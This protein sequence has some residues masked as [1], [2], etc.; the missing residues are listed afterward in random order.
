MGAGSTAPA[1]LPGKA[2][3]RQPAAHA[4]DAARMRAICSDILAACRKGDAGP[5]T[6]DTLAARAGMSTFHF[7]RRFKAIVGVTPG[8]FIAAARLEHFKRRLGQNGTIGGALYDAGYGSPSRVYERAGRVLGMTPG[9]YRRGGEGLNISYAVLD[10]PVGRLLIA[11][12]DRGICCTRFGESRRALVRDLRAEYP[13]ARI[14]PARTGGNP[15]FAAWAQAIAR[16]LTGGQPHLDLPLDVR[17][18]AFQIKVWQCLRTIPYGERRSYTQVAAAIGQPRA[19]RAVAQ[20]C[21][22]NPVALLVPCHRV[23]RSSGDLGGYRWGVRR[24]ATLL[25]RERRGLDL[26]RRRSDASQ[27]AVQGQAAQDVFPRHEPDE[28]TASVDDGNLRHAGL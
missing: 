25:A 9:E 19:T 28:L 8:Q 16:H 12:T 4:D 23:L 7:A 13:A 26:R 17:G 10:T 2:A 1:A 15:Q 20:A 22:R 27:I 5:L 11:A 18:T 21:A 3:S 6:L 14:V 24:K